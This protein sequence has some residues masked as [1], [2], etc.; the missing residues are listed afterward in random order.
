MTVSG[1]QVQSSIPHSGLK[2]ACSSQWPAPLQ[3][4]AARDP[5]NVIV[6]NCTLGF[7]AVVSAVHR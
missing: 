7:H 3:E 5:R 6:R 4:V 1:V 2:L